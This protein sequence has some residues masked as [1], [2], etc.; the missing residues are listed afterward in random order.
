MGLLDDLLPQIRIALSIILICPLTSTSPA[1]MQDGVP[2]T[3]PSNAFQHGDVPGSIETWNDMTPALLQQNIDAI[4]KA[5]EKVTG[6]K[7]GCHR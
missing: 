3:W 1:H 6:K 4:Q 5:W 2:T 7:C